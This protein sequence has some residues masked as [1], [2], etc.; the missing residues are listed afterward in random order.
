MRWIIKALLQILSLYVLPIFKY[1]LKY[2]AQI[3][4]AQYGAAMSVYLQNASKGHQR[5]GRK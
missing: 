1:L 5:G 4:K 3:Q 2:F